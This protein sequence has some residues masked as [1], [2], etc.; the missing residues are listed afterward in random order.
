MCVL[1]PLD[2][3]NL[4]SG[5]IFQAF[6]KDSANFGCSIFS[7]KESFSKAFLKKKKI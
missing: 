3:S 1:T 5:K 2:A 7:K 4:S 6:L